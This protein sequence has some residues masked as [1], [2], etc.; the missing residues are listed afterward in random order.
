MEKNHVD[1]IMCSMQGT[2]K[3]AADCGIRFVANA[4]GSGRVPEWIAKNL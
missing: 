4:G 3:K 1:E 2:S